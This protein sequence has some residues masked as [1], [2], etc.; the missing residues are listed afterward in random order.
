MGD[1]GLCQAK[2]LMIEP[3]QM[4]RLER[5][6]DRSSDKKML[7]LEHHTLH[8]KI[9]GV[10]SFI[11]RTCLRSIEPEQMHRLDRAFDHHSVNKAYIYGNRM[12][13]TSLG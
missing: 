10:I 9:E 12:G 4:P 3:Q 2:A 11:Y 6:L 13:D 5:V 1:M 7:W 8:V